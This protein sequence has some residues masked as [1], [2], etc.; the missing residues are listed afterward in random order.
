MSVLEFDAPVAVRTIDIDAPLSDLVLPPAENGAPYTGAYVLATR[1][2]RPAG[3]FAIET[4][5]GAT[6]SAT[7]LITAIERMRLE[8]PASAPVDSA[9]PSPGEPTVPLVT[10]VV[11]TVDGGETAHRTID[12][13]LA[14]SH[15]NVEVVLVNNRPATTTIE[16]LIAERYAGEPRVRAVTEDRPGL[17][18]ARNAGLAVASG[19]IIAFTDDDAVPDPAWLERVVATFA[20]CPDAACVTGLIVPLK[21]ET[22]AQVLLERFAG[23]SKGFDRQRYSLADHEDDPLFPYAA[24]RFGSGANIALRGDAAR[25]L[26]GFDGVLGT[27][28]PARGGEDLDLFMRVLLN[29]LTL[30]YEPAAMIW[31][32]HPDTIE[33]IEREVEH[34]GSGLSAAIAKQLVCGPR[35]R[36]LLRGLV[37][38]IRYGLSPN[39]PKNARKG[40]RYPLRFT[41][42]EL[43][44][45]IYGPVGYARS[46]WRDARFD[47]L[48]K[49]KRGV[50][51]GAAVATGAL[52]GA[53]DGIE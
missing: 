19:E 33:H 41:V 20:E 53:G 30:V 11:C 7:S 43:V 46:R 28:T 34:Y 5:R 3:T 50:L 12:A 36:R 52:A 48:K 17:S 51:V 18:Y 44:G 27:G 14:G 9:G 21:L 31:H 13:V 1:S 2:G 39:S 10:V 24:G 47:A 32:E 37:A 23:Y 49:T 26:G 22:E 4:D 35:R 8:S 45:V 15:S 29:S 40:A 6:I 42:A 16:P 25:T 38:G